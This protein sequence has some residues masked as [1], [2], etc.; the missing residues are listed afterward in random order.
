MK[1]W[2]FLGLLS[3]ILQANLMPTTT[4]A[5]EPLTKTWYKEFWE[6][7]AGDSSQAKL[8][9][10]KK[11]NYN[12]IIMQIETGYNTPASS[13]NS[14]NNPFDKLREAFQ[15]CS[16]DDGCSYKTE[17]DKIKN[18]KILSLKIEQCYAN[19]RKEQSASE[20]EVTEAGLNVAG[21][22]RNQTKLEKELNLECSIDAANNI[23]STSLV[24]FNP[25]GTKDKETLKGE[26][27]NLHSLVSEEIKTAINDFIHA[28]NSK[29][30]YD[31]QESFINKSELDSPDQALAII[32]AFNDIVKIDK[33]LPPIT[34]INDSNKNKLFYNGKYMTVESIAEKYK[35]ADINASQEG[36]N[37]ENM[38]DSIGNSLQNAKDERARLIKSYAILKKNA[39]L[40]MTNLIDERT[41]HTDGDK[42]SSMYLLESRIN[43]ALQADQTTEVRPAVILRQIRDAINTSNKLNYLIYQTEER[44]QMALAVNQISQLKPLADSINKKTDQINELNMKIDLGSE[45][46]ETGK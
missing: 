25:S 42:H 24:K 12:D 22:P 16:H 13:E 3:Q 35:L 45:T 21:M 43:N 34:L 29:N 15:N 36:N 9:P 31:T 8:K 41:K 6:I 33:Y 30:N 38:R 23:M 2:I 5:P 11:N 40:N 4:D 20:P 10:A 44:I 19:L 37:I 26:M 32:N 18:L 1:K 39:V 46:L 27:R 14:N 7:L 28:V 17:F